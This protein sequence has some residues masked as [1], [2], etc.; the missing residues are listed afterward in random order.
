MLQLPHRAQGHEK[1]GS[2]TPPRHDTSS[3]ATFKD[4]KMDKMPGEEFE[5]VFA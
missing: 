3:A 2:M 4:I 5:S 1:P